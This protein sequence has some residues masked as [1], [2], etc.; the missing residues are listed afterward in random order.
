MEQFLKALPGL[1][2]K[3]EKSVYC[4]QGE[5]EIVAECE[6]RKTVRVSF[7]TKWHAPHS[8]LIAAV[9]KYHPL[10]L[11][12]HL[13]W[14]DDDGGLGPDP[15]FGDAL[16][17]GPD[18]FGEFYTRVLGETWFSEGQGETNFLAIDRSADEYADCYGDWFRQRAAAGTAV[19]IAS[20]A[21]LRSMVQEAYPEGS[22]LTAKFPRRDEG[23]A[24]RCAFTRCPARRPPSRIGSG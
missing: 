21:G 22:I 15:L 3:D 24:D 5:P 11:D 19:P 13:W 1:I 2:G 23:L 18:C 16:V 4:E 14:H 12:F 20:E 10:G 9:R 17:V 8:I 7:E 6:G